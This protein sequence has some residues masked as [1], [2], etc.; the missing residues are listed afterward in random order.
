MIAY[1]AKMLPQVDYQRIERNFPFSI[2]S[3]EYCAMQDY[4]D[5][6]EYLKSA[7]SRTFD[8]NSR[9]ISSPSLCLSRNYGH[10]THY[11]SS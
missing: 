7:F 11:P 9:I 8:T 4:C 1:Q 3:L 10:S 5:F 6:L 2:V